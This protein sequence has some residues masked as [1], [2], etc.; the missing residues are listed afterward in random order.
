MLADG[1]LVIL[2]PFLSP[3][4]AIPE[5]LAI[6]RLHGKNCYY[7]DDRQMPTETRK[8][9]LQQWE[10]LMDAM[11]KW[12]ADNGYTRKQQPVRNFLDRWTLYMESEEFQVKSPG[13]VQF[14]LHR[15]KYNSTYAPQM[16]WPLRLTNYIA[17]FAVLIVG[18]QRSHLLDQWA[19]KAFAFL[20]RAPKPLS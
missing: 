16:R 14:F 20:R 4:L 1:Y 15:M 19:A 8:S 6:Y 2:I 10:I 5:F 11:R 18:Y 7:A 17:A 12:L 3:V 9:R 13:R